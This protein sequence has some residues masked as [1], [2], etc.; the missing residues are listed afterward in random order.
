MKV[1]GF[2]KGPFLMLGTEIDRRK[3]GGAGLFAVEYE[4]SIR[5]ACQRGRTLAN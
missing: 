1:R 5:A 4:S 3:G 2:R